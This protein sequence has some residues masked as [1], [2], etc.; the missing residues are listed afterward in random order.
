MFKFRRNRSFAVRL[1]IGI[2]CLCIV[3]LYVVDFGFIVDAGRRHLPLMRHFSGAP[4]F[5][6]NRIRNEQDAAHDNNDGAAY[7]VNTAGCRMPSFPVHGPSMDQ[8]WRK[9][10]ISNKHS[11]GIRPLTESDGRNGAIWVAHNRSVLRHEFDVIDADDLRCSVTPFVRR[12]DTVNEFKATVPLLFG[13]VVYVKASFARV[14]CDFAA[15]SNNNVSLFVTTDATIRT[16]IEYHYFFHVPTDRQRG[17]DDIT[18]PTKTNANASPEIT[19]TSRDRINVLILGINSVSR[20]NLHRQMPQTVDRLLN[21]L[22]AVE[23]FGYNSVE[24]STLP[25]LVPALSGLE[26]KELVATCLPMPNSTFDECNFIWDLFAERGYKTAFA[27]DVS[28]LGTFNHKQPGFRRQPADFVLRPFVL[29]MEKDHQPDDAIN[30]YEPFDILIGFVRKFVAAFPHAPYFMW[31]WMAGSPNDWNSPQRIDDKVVTLLDDLDAFNNTFL[32]LTSDHGFRFPATLR[33]SYQGLMEERQPFL[34]LVPPR[35]FPDRYPDAYLNLLRNR[36]RLTTPFD[37]YETL[38]DLLEPGATLNA[39]MLR[40]RSDALPA[41]EP[42]PRGISLFL[43]VPE[44]RMCMQAGIL[45]QWC[46]CHE[47]QP[48]V[49]RSARVLR[50]ARFIVQH[51]NEMVRGFSGCQRLALYTIS[52]ATVAGTSADIVGIEAKSKTKTPTTVTSLADHFADVTVRL[53]TKPGLGEFEA[54]VRVHGNRRDAAM[55]FTGAINRMNANGRQSE[56]EK[57]ATIQL[58][59]FCDSFL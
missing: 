17:S 21:R 7:F 15:L 14:S 36:H 51:L 42:M 20:L 19:T 59:C 23:L 5:D 55:M 6:W 40:Q 10:K 13:E 26:L 58:Y 3:L 29:E 38:G 8:F 11:A 24:E 44:R 12:S 30:D 4:A 41:M 34:F 16:I 49:K 1:L 32:L 46:T 48:I 18:A 25:N 35:T 39:D 57:N 52:D 54:T 2:V 47:S 53:L 9:V 22:H 31:A 28:D 37:L 45:S 27:E 50:V 56:C 33:S 43:P